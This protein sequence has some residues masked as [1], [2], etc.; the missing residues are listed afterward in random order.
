MLGG[1]F[2]AEGLAYVGAALAFGAGATLFGSL[3]S[4]LSAVARTLTAAAGTL[5]SII[6]FFVDRG[7]S[8]ETVR[9]LMLPLTVVLGLR[10]GNS[11]STVA[12]PHA[13]A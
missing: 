9:W 8:G 13:P 6:W 3:W 7:V 12:A 11:S 5:V 4:E 1:F 2:L 10:P